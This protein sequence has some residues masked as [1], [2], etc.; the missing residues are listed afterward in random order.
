MISDYEEIVAVLQKYVDGER[1]ADADLQAQAFYEDATIHGMFGPEMWG[2]P[3][4]ML[5]DAV[6]ESEP[7]PD[8]KARIDVLDIAETAAVARV[9]LEGG[10]GPDYVDYHCLVKGP[11]GWKVAAKI[12]HPILPE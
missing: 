5:F 2:G 10:E 11:E 1:N 4:Q 7:N 6:R 8:M 9:T 3:I 12:F